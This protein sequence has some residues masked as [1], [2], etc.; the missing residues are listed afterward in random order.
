MQYI[1]ICI[2]N[3]T[4]AVKSKREREWNEHFIPRL[5]SRLTDA[6]GFDE[7]VE[8][9]QHIGLDKVKISHN[10]DKVCDR[11]ARVNVDYFES[12]LKSKCKTTK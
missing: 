5:H 2:T 1:E 11:R 4:T 12:Y 9:V 8:L 6:C 3:S 10:L 7:L